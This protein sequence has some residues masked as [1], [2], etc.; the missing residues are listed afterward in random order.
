MKAILVLTVVLIGAATIVAFSRANLVNTVVS[1]A[2]SEPAALLI[3][4]GALLG[5]AGALRRYAA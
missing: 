1:R 3:S 5:V 2:S 4:G